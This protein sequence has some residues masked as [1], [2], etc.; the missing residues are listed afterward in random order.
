[1]YDLFLFVVME[2]LE[3]TAISSIFICNIFHQIIHKA[4]DL[5]SHLC[6]ILDILLIWTLIDQ[7]ELNFLED[8]IDFFAM[9]VPETCLIILVCQISISSGLLKVKLNLK[10]GEEKF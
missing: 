6:W 8:E 4:N 9:I 1:M 10:E 3:T 2:V 5:L 7:A